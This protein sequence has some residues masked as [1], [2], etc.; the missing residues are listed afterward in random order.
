VQWGGLSGGHEPPRAG[1]GYF[2]P[3]LALR[4]EIHH[5]PEPDHCAKM[6]VRQRSAWTRGVGESKWQLLRAGDTLWGRPWG[7]GQGHT[8]GMV[9][10][11]CQGRDTKEQQ[12][13]EINLGIA[14]TAAETNSCKY[15]P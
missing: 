9:D 10:G 4:G 2:P 3:A 11:L 1:P 7:R 12:Q 13:K 15:Y 14:V 6:A 8:R 5:A